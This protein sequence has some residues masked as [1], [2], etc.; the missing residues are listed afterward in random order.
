MTTSN[1]A[2][3]EVEVA[4]WIHAHVVPVLSEG[5]VCAMRDQ[6][7]DPA[8]YL[9]E[10]L[11]AKGAGTEVASALAA[12]KL[13]GECAK[14]DMELAA[15]HEQ[16][17][18]AQEEAQRRVPGSMAAE[19][20]ARDEAAAAAQWQEMRR[21]KRLM[22]TMKLKTEE[23]LDASEW[24]LP[25]GVLLVQAAPGVPADVLCT[26]LSTDFAAHFHRWEPSAG[27]EQLGPVLGALARTPGSFGLA[28]GCF[29]GAAT[30]DDVI[31]R[32]GMLSGSVNPAALVLLTGGGEAV[33]EAAQSDWT[34]TALPALQEG[35]RAAQLQVISVACQGDYEEDMSSL[36]VAVT[37]LYD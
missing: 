24:L 35:C 17:E 19:A 36:L 10:F 33:D 2:A 14:L 3:A 15:V 31:A 28:L 1:L 16:L 25:E 13:A 27:V 12:R 26:Q 34:A 9:A 23:T 21:L 11:A 7:P 6:P 4:R 22:R 37:D 29:D 20:V 5:V 32:L 8:A 18:A 30:A